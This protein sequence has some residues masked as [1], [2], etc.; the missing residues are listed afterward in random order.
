M[1]YLAITALVLGLM[2]ACT[3]AEYTSSAG[4]HV[5]SGG[6]SS[7]GD[8]HDHDEV[9]V[10]PEAAARVA[11]LDAQDV[12][13]PTE[14]LGLV[15]VHEPVH[16]EQEALAELREHA[17]AM[18]ADAVIGVEFHHGDTHAGPTHLS[19]LAVR[20]RDLLQG[21]SYD[22]LSTIAVTE[23]MGHHD[24]ALDEL[25][26]RARDLHADLIINIGYEH[27]DAESPTSQLHGTAIRFR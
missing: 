20:F 26:G 14:V 18:G 2:P 27:G 5:A 6:H 15:D 12:G 3:E 11:V 17:A 22:V 7:G 13:R 1:R 10:S 21:R 19:G 25:R 9:H 23:R 4:E 16:N 24:D 8:D